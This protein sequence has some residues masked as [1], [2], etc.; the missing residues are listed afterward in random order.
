[1]TRSI[2]ACSCA[3]NPVRTVVQ[4][5]IFPNH[6]TTFRPGARVMRVTLQQLIEGRTDTTGLDN[7][8]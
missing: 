8:L 1:M 2:T 6:P 7:L 4:W 5:K 3:N